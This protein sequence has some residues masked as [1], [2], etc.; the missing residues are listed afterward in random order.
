MSD[1]PITSLGAITGATVASG[2]LLELVDISDTTMAG[3][4]TNKKLTY[5]NLI[6]ALQTGLG[7]GS[8]ATLSTVTSSQLTDGTVANVDLA[9]MTQATVKGRAAG[10]G[11]GAPVDLT[12]TQLTALVN[13]F[14]SS[15]SGAAPSSGGG[16]TNFL[17]ADGTWASPPG[18]GRGT[19]LGTTFSPSGSIGS[20]DVQHAIE[21]LDTDLTA[22]PSLAAGVDIDVST[23]SGVTTVSVL[24][25]SSQKWGHADYV[26]CATDAS[27]GVASSTTQVPDSAMTGNL[28]VVANATYAFEAVIFYT[29]LA[30]ADIKASWRGP[31]GS[32]WVFRLTGPDT[33]T[34]T[35]WKGLVADQTNFTLQFGG[36]DA[37]QVAFE[38]RG[39]INTV[40]TPGT[41]DFWYAQN[42]SQTTATIRKAGSYMKIQRLA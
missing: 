7:L 30:T 27:P 22:M 8:L 10:A 16:T 4:G 31:T 24:N 1:L 17:R 18:A 20:N 35:N 9:N 13:T 34:A 3:T 39:I 28:S 38:T 32:T 29:A 11:T 14:T 2:D 36:N 42:V 37:T 15:L 40:G 33:T 19:A 12:Q 23:T 21:E 5:A 25:T 26:V 6:T 41:I